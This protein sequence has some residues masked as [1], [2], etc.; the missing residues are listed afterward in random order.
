MCGCVPLDSRNFNLAERQVPGTCA[1][2]VLFVAGAKLGCELFLV[3]DFFGEIGDRLEAIV[4]GIAMPE[5][6]GSAAGERLD[7][8]RHRDRMTALRAGILRGQTC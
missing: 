2:V 4:A 1:R 3:D 8:V 6:S 5:E 7:P